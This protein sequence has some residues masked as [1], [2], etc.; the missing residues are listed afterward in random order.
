MFACFY[1]PDFP[2]QAALLIE[3]PQARN[4]FKQSPLAILDGPANLPRVFALNPPA[5][6]A[7]I[8]SGMTKLQVETYGGVLLRKRIVSLE[9]SAQSTLMEFAGGFS[10]RVEST[11]AGTVT[12][13][14]SGSEKLLGP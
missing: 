13:D 12:L 9:D 1:V 8:E 4:V 3:L 7:G 5:L 6:Q 11:A 14:L 10:P 2:V